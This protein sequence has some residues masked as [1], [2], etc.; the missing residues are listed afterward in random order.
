MRKTFLFLILIASVAI[1]AK[2][3]YVKTDGNDVTGDGTSWETAFASPVKAFNEAAA[4]DVVAIMQGTYNM[5]EGLNSAAVNLQ[6]EGGFT[7]T[8]DER[9]VDPSNTIFEYAGSPV[10][11]VISNYGSGL[12]FSGITFQ[13]LQ[14]EA[15]QYGIFVNT[16]GGALTLEDCVVRNFVNKAGLYIRGIFRFNATATFTFERC[17]FIDCEEK[18]TANQ[19]AVITR[20]AGN[21]TVIIK[22]SIIKG[23]KTKPFVSGGAGG[24][25]THTITNCTFINNPGGAGTNL[26]ASFTTMITNSIFFNSALTGGGSLNYSYYNGGIGNLTPANSV[27]FNVA[28]E[29]FE[30]EVNFYPALN[31]AG[32]D[33]GDNSVATVDDKDIAGNLRVA[34]S[35]VDVGAYENISAPVGAVGS[36]VTNVGVAE[37]LYYPYGSTAQI[38]ITVASGCVPDPIDGVVF[39]GTNPEF[40][41]NVAV[42][43]PRTITFTATQ[44]SFEVNVSAT[45]VTVT[46]PT[47]LDGKYL[48]S[49]N[50]LIYFTQNEGTEN[51]TATVN[52]NSVTPVQINGNDYSLALEGISGPTNVVISATVKEYTVTLNKDEFIATI[53][54]LT[55]GSQQKQH[56]YNELS[57]TLAEGAHSPYVSI[58]GVNFPAVANEGVYSVPSFSITEA[59][60]IML[61]AYA[62]NVLPVSEDTYQRQGGVISGNYANEN[63]LGSRGT[64]AGWAAIPLLKFVLTD[65][66]KSV[67]YAKVEL[68]L[69]PKATHTKSYSYTVRQFPTVDFA[70]IHVVGANDYAKL[71]NATA[72]G[73]VDQPVSN[74]QQNVPILLNVSDEYVLIAE[75]DD[76]ILS[77]VKSSEGTMDFFHSFENGK[78]EYV[79][80]LIFSD[81][82]VTSSSTIKDDLEQNLA[83]KKYYSLHGIEVLKPI[84]GSI[85]IVKQ[86]SKVSKEIFLRK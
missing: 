4:D 2:T 61:S 49:A 50:S 52:G 42:K 74:V 67:G 9:I 73:T 31:F 56:G 27:Q 48:S 26:A 35:T 60:T 81:R 71:Q 32:I 19:N 58:N 84:E 44:A 22:N 86:G 54:G 47:L 77:V 28:N 83:T 6:V 46:S 8:G 79:P 17:Q 37:G 40:I 15:S 68:R 65:H 78:A 12:K 20:N 43:A 14:P 62:E 53:T 18:S 36:N 10:A 13:N 76:V 11:R 5:T 7:G 16:S 59:S 1:Q 34:N 64:P 21:A 70:T 72:V 29:V 3:I 63:Q 25:N 57:F 85:Y 41:A 82:I 66:L 39:I 24:T 55:E 38:P 69:V 45:N 75:N 33:T 23:T 30:D 51:L 80:Q